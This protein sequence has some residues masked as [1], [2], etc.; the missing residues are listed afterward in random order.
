MSALGWKGRKPRV[1]IGYVDRLDARYSWEVYILGR[2]AISVRP[3]FRG[4]T[5]TLEE[6]QRQVEEMLDLVGEY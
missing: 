4:W 5:D 3:V 6:A 1:G 2:E